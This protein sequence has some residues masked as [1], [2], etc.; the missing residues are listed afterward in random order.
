MINGMDKSECWAT[1]QEEKNKFS[2]THMG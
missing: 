2:T 1:G